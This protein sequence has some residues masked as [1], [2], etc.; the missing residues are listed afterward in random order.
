MLPTRNTSDLKSLTA[1]APAKLIISG[2]HSVLYGQPALAMAINRYTSVTTT[3]SATAKIHFDLLDLSY[4]KSYTSQALRSFAKNLQADYSNFLAGEKNIGSVIK[5]PF[6]LLQY[7]VS[8]LLEVLNVKLARGVDICVESNIPIGCGMG[9]SAAA[10]ASTVS[11]LAALLH[12]DWQDSDQLAFCREIENLQHGKSSGLDLHLVTYGGCVRFE[13]GATQQRAVPKI[14]LNIVNTGQPK[15]ST[16]A[17]VA[18]VAPAFTNDPSLANEFAVIT[19][20]IDAALAAN[21]LLEFKQGIRANHSLL[22]RIG[23]VPD[24]V[25]NFINEI[26]ASGG[27][28]KI[29]G[30]GA[31]L[32]DNAGI[33]LLVADHDVQDIVRKYNYD[34]QSIQVDTNGI[35]II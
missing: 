4:A 34:L 35:T 6:E 31:V 5:R 11:A 1:T 28:A 14:P 23:V 20:Q 16:G 2:E 32:G 13:D 17:C 9:S 25:A 24:K 3:W 30:A 18:H 12:C 33:V 21:N 8:R 10:V 29:C 22:R 15:S 26:E 7:S 27:A 19:N